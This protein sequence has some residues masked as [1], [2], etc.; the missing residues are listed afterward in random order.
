MSNLFIKKNRYNYPINDFVKF[1][2]LKKKKKKEYGWVA[3]E[4][5]EWSGGNWRSLISNGLMLFIFGLF[6]CLRNSV[7]G[8][9]IFN[10]F[11]Q[12]SNRFKKQLSKKKKKII[13]LFSMNFFTNWFRK[14]FCWKIITENFKRKLKKKNEERERK[15]KP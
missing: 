15:K 7:I 2:L 14:F 4:R 10:W 9:K 8:G 3:G 6:V 12:I 13:I 1:L 11:L 5:E